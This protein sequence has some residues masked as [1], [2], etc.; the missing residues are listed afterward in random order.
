[1]DTTF[2]NQSDIQSPSLTPESND[3]DGSTI[4]TAIQ[5]IEY[6]E[7]RFSSF[8]QSQTEMM[9]SQT[10]MMQLLVKVLGKQPQ[11]LAPITPEVQQPIN[12]PKKENTINTPTVLKILG[13]QSPVEASIIPVVQQQITTPVKEIAVNIPPVSTSVA[14]STLQE[15]SETPITTASLAAIMATFL[16]AS[17]IQDKTAKPTGAPVTLTVNHIAPSAIIPTATP[18]LLPTIKT[19]FIAPTIKPPIPTYIDF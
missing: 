2:T 12:T 8:E 1:M 7:Q 19:V 16:K 3:Y 6:L 10:E 17:T 15:D 18:T 9:Q 14:T 11:D 4:P 13:K 5:R